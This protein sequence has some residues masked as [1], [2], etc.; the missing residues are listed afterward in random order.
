MLDPPH[1]LSKQ[2]VI[3][4]GARSKC[5]THLLLRRNGIHPK[6][7][8]NALIEAKDAIGGRR[9]DAIVAG[10]ETVRVDEPLPL[11]VA[12]EKEQDTPAGC[13]EQEKETV[14]EN[15][16]DGVTETVVVAV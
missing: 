6:S 12:G 3:A 4:M 5:K 9:L 14:C 2:N 16:L 10:N 8:A 11:T 13:P 1:P 15:P 7:R